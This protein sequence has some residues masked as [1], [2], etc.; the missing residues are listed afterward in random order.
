MPDKLEGI[1]NRCLA[2]LR[3]AY[4]RYKNYGARSN[5]KLKPLHGWVAKELRSLL[6]GGYSVVGL[7]DGDTGEVRI[8]GMYYPKNVD[9]AISREGRVIGVVS[10]KFVISNYRQ[11]A[12]NYLETQMGE[13]ANLRRN[14]IVFGHLLC[15]RL[16]I[17]YYTKNK[18][19]KKREQLNDSD[20]S[21]YHKLAQD[22]NH[23][24]APDVQGVVAA[25]WDERGD[26]IARLCRREDLHDLSDKSHKIM[27]E[28]LNVKRFFRVLSSKIEDKYQEIK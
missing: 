11:N 14:N 8:N 12:N 18:E 9:V 4:R 10:V 20:I 3:E 5:E 17:P 2:A 6:G 25:R 21:K 19:I 15:V 28:R 27:R 26:R 7:D 16:P 23:P 1:E 22:H 24:H 13:T